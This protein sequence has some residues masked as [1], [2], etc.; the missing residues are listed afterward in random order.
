MTIVVDDITTQ[1]GDSTACR[2][3][4]GV[5]D[6]INRHYH[7]AQDK[8]RKL[9]IYNAGVYIPEGEEV[10]QWAYFRILERLN[11]TS[12]WKSKIA[13]EVIKLFKIK[14]AE[15][16]ETPKLEYLNV[17]NGMIN[18]QTFEIVEHDPKYLSTIQL[19]VVYRPE[20]N[21]DNWDTFI[22]EVFPEDAQQVPWELIAWLMVP[23]TTIQKVILFHG[24]G[25]NGK[26]IFLEALQSFLGFDHVS[27]VPLHA[28]EEDRFATA[29][30]IGKLANVCADLPDLKIKTTGM[31]KA[32]TG[33]DRV[34]IEEKFRASYDAILP[35][36]LIF[37]ANQLPKSNDNSE[38]FYRRM[39]II[40][41]EKTFED[42]PANKRSIMAGLTN[43]Y[44]LSGVLNKALKLVHK[45]LNSGLYISPKM[46]SVLD[47]YRTLTDPMAKWLEAET[48]NN[49]YKTT[50][51]IDIFSSY[52]NYCKISDIMPLSYPAFF[53]T[54]KKFR[55]DL[56]TVSRRVTGAERLE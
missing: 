8:S 34:T 13:E 53:A 44:Q 10:I 15:L 23:C 14:S 37:S 26:S 55:P 47:N 33:F 28:L 52:E 39:I 20:C 35:A 51:K 24:T 40:P 56:Q 5:V 17:K 42:V 18:I 30:L 3:T 1:D 31:L 6:I 4:S 27:S 2:T 38:G 21:C 22:S 25:A 45:V 50:D 19:P 46:K 49:Q 12:L 43:Q 16:P 32:L 29:R 7:I 48:L 54:L 9:Y 41:M 36:R 11:L